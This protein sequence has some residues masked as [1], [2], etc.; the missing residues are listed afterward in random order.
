MHAYMHIY[1]NYIHNNM[2][3]RKKSS[4][5]GKHYY[6]YSFNEIMGHSVL[7]QKLKNEF[8][9]VLD[10]KRTTFKDVLSPC[11]SFSGE[12]NHVFLSEK[13]R[14]FYTHAQKKKAMINDN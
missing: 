8:S 1:I 11:Q 13:L 4:S 5:R 6:Y 3:G 2:K 7:Y 12:V 9:V 14:T 10:K